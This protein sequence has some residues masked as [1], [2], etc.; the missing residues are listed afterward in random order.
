MAEAIFKDIS[1]PL[2]HAQ[3][4]RM[5]RRGLGKSHGGFFKRLWGFAA[6][7]LIIVWIPGFFFPDHQIALYE[8]LAR[9]FG[10]S[11]DTVAAAISLSILAV[12]LAVLLAIVR[13]M[14]NAQSRRVGEKVDWTITAE[15]GGLRYASRNLDYVLRWPG[16]HQV[17][18]EREGFILVHG[19]SYFFVPHEAFPTPEDRR[20]FFRLLAASLPAEALARSGVALSL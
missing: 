14:R 1:F 6:L 12:F 19:N 18:A 5:H 8:R 13:Q 2:S 4:V 16:F 15:E 20:V 3:Q 7:V 17:F 9:K 11:C 10:V